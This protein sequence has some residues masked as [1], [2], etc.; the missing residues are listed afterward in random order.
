MN[1]LG[2]LTRVQPYSMGPILGYA[3]PLVL[4]PSAGTVLAIDAP[5]IPILLCWRAPA[6]VR[7]AARMLGRPEP[8]LRVPGLAEVMERAGLGPKVTVT[9]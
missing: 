6:E 9:A 7:R 1:W 2:D 8:R 4:L 5:H 3:E